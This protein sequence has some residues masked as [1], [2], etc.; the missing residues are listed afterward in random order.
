[1]TAGE[2]K[3]YADKLMSERQA[4]LKAEEAKKNKNRLSPE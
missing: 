4:R 1:M 2:A 3:A